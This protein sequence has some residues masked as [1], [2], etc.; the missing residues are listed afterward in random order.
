MY[1]SVSMINPDNKKLLQEVKPLVFVDGIEIFNKFMEENIV[2]KTGFFVV[3]PSG[4]GKTHFVNNQKEHHWIDGDLLWT[5]TGAHPDEAWWTQGLEKIFEV[6]QRSDVITAAAKKLGLWIVGASH[7]WIIPDA[8]VIPDWEVH[9]KQ[10][11]YREENNYDGGATSKDFTQVLNHRSHL[12]KFAKEKNIPIF[13]NME[14]VHEFF[15]KK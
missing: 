15:M 1:T 4:A 9:K 13:E 12:E 10:I 6:D 7:Y 5:S 11:I 2:H 3:A 14:A 8:I